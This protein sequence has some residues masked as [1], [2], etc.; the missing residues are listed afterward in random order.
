MGSSIRFLINNVVMFSDEGIKKGFI[1]IS[2]GKIADLGEEPPPE[3]ELSELV[4]DYEGKALAIHGFSVLASLTD[5]PFRGIREPDLS[6]YSRQELEKFAQAGIYELLLNG[7]TFP[8]IEDKHPEI[9]VHLL[10]SLELKGALVVEKGA[11]KHYPDII[12]LEKKNDK[13]Y[14]NDRLLGKYDEIFCDIN[15]VPSQIDKCMAYSLIGSISY[16]VSALITQAYRSLGDKIFHILTNS[17]RM[18]GIDKGTITKASK[19]DLLIYS[20]KDSLKTAPLTLDPLIMSAR[21]Y[22]P[23]QVIISGDIFFDKYESLVIAKPNIDQ[24]VNRGG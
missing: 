8:I 18:L 24:I 1:F 23:D 20:S 16:N 21:G 13:I 15:N 9:V 4:Y 10:K 5:Y 14:Y 22:P 12:I 17:Y 7:V 6:V 11:V 2:N 19:A 3:Y